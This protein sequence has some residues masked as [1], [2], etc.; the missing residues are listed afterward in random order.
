MC[1]FNDPSEYTDNWL[2]D[3][4]Q[5]SKAKEERKRRVKKEELAELLDACELASANLA[6]CWRL[7]V[8]RS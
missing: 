4:E 6:C 2:D 3:Q 5:V 7:P 8:T 1:K